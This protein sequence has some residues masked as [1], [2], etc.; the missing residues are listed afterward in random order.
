MKTFRISRLLPQTGKKDSPGTVRYLGRQRDHTIKIHLLDYNEGQVTERE[1]GSISEALP[2][3][4]NFSVTWLNITGVH[5]TK[6]IEEIGAHFNVHPLVLEDIANTTQRPKLEEYDDYLFIVLKMVYTQPKTKNVAIEQV[7]LLVG[8]SYVISFQETDDDVFEDVR[9]RIREGKGK[10][11]KCG[12]DYLAYTIT[13]AITD[14]YFSVL[15]DMGGY[16]EDMEAQLLLSPDQPVLNAIYALKQELVYVRKS[17]WPI[18]EVIAGLQR[19]ESDLISDDI[20]PYFRDV[21]DHTV[22]IIETVES[23]RD[24]TAGMLDLYVS[25]VSN[26]MN[27]IMKVLTIFASIFIPLTFIVGVYGMN[28]HNMPELSLPWGYP[29]VWGLMITIAV[30]L[31]IFFKKKGWM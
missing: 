17:I 24:M 23:F 26:K 11:R 31:L 27:E 29:A 3:K 16:L 15:E 6:A 18:R 9:K 10:I 8:K 12:T 30:I 2:F 14:N 1:L 20:A 22:Q 5:D 13:D 7:S 21:Y 28:F 19:S 4:D 25:T